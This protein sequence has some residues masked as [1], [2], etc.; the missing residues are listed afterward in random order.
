MTVEQTIS[1]IVLALSASIILYGNT[2]YVIRIHKDKASLSHVII[3]STPTGAIVVTAISLLLGLMFKNMAITMILI[4]IVGVIYGIV[5]VRRPDAALDITYDWGPMFSAGYD[6]RGMV[7]L[8][9]ILEII[10]M[11]GL[12]IAGII[13]S[14]LVP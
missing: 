2:R 13:L 7:Y 9:T 11:I 1:L 6:T 8:Y 14:P 5:I 4:G 10:G 3:A 12:I